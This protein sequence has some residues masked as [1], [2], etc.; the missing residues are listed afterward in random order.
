MAMK[1]RDEADIIELN[2]RYH[3][4]QGV[5]EFIVTDNGSTDGTL[6]V[7]ERWR[8]RRLPAPDQRA[9]RGRTSATRGT[10]G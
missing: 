9:E 7:L 5:D 8:D 3:H 10:G 2:L 6:E 4:A 1:V